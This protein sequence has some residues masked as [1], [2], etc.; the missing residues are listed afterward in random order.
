[1]KDD[2]P[3]HPSGWHRIPKDD[4]WKAVHLAYVAESGRRL[5]LYCNVC[6]RSEFHWPREFAERHQLDMLTP[7]LLIERRLKCTTC[8]VRKMTLREE[9]YSIERDKLGRY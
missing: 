5:W 8:K 6:C 2:G 4:A 1:M 7:L 9:S 3:D